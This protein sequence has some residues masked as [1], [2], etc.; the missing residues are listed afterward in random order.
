M[1]RTLSVF[2]AGVRAGTLSQDDVGARS[3]A[4]DDGYAGPPLSLSMPVSNQ[5]FPSRVVDAYLLGLLPD[6][7]RMRREAGRLAVG[8][9]ALCVPNV[10]E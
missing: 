4:Y 9:T 6:D 2:V 7:D 10:H 8:A 3:F 1:T 5:T